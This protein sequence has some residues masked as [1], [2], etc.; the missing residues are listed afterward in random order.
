MNSMKCESCGESRNCI[1][2]CFIAENRWRNEVSM[3]FCDA[4]R[5]KYNELGARVADFSNLR[6][7]NRHAYAFRVKKLKEGIREDLR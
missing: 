4:C 5:T 7:L 6:H 1:T 3:Y 2:A